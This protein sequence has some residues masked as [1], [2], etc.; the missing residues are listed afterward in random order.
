M[1]EIRAASPE[2]IADIAALFRASFRA[3]L[4]HLEL[5]TPEEDVAFFGETVLPANHVLIAVEPGSGA[6]A[7]FIAFT[8]E[9]VNHLYI[10]PASQRQGIGRMLLERAKEQSTHLQLWTFQVNHNA[11]QFYGALGFVEVAWTD[12]SRNEERE[13]DVLLEWRRAAG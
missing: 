7:G 10:A 5:H 12:G 4:P 9:W 3:V 8:A 6:I 2:H 13:P 11:R 1:Y